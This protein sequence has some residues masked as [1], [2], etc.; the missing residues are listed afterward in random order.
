MEKKINAYL[1]NHIVKKIYYYKKKNLVTIRNTKLT[2]KLFP[3][4]A[5]LHRENI[6]A[7]IHEFY[8]MY[9]VTENTV[10]LKMSMPGKY[11]T[12]KLYPQPSL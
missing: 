9:N 7:I 8:S 11:S 10:M 4:P 3:S 5:Q 12:T 2:A 6:L 1:G